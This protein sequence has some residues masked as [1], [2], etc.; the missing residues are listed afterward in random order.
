[1]SGLRPSSGLS[2]CLTACALLALSASA[3]A[4]SAAGIWSVSGQDPQHGP[5]TG[6]VEL[7]AAPGGGYQFVRLI[8]LTQT[9]HAGRRI[10]SAWTGV[11][12]DTGGGVGVDLTLER[13]GWAGS[14]AGIT[15]SAADG[16]PAQV[17]GSFTLQNGA[18]T[19]GWTG[20]GLAL[21]AS[22]TWTR[23]GPVGAAPLWRNER[24]IVGMHRAPG[25][26]VK[27]LM[28]SIFRSYHQTAW[29]QPYVARPDFQ[30]AV[31]SAIHDPTDFDLHRREPDLL[32]VIQRVIDPLSLE[33]AAIKADAY[34]QTLR[35][36]AERADA[37]MPTFIEPT[38]GTL[39]YL[40]NGQAE[41]SGDGDL[42]TG[43]YALSQSLRWQATQD[44]VALA[45]LERSAR[46]AAIAM[47]ID[48]DP[49]AFARTVIPARATPRG[50]KWHAGSG[51]YQ[52]LE[53]LE[54][55]N[56]DMFKGLV[57]TGLAAHEALPA[58]HPLRAELG[59]GLSQ[60]A[61]LSPVANKKTSGNGLL[62]YGLA[63]L[64]TGSSADKDAY[65]RTARNPFFQL[66][67]LLDG[68]FFWQGISDWSG[69]HLGICGVWSRVR[70]S[71]HLNE[72]VEHLA[73]R[74]ALR[75]AEARLRPS[76]PTLH[77]IAAAGRG[78]LSWLS[79]VDASDA[80]WSLR[81]IPFPRS[82][83]RTGHGLRADFSLSPYPSLPWKFDWKTNQ[84]RVQGLVVP[85]RFETSPDIYGWKDNPLASPARG[86]GPGER[87]GAVDY[88]FAYWLAR[89]EGVVGPND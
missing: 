55:G 67:G 3:S 12:H 13:M 85:P 82:E 36:K 65:R 14:G 89:V 6:Q 63:G 74:L 58:G 48:G 35:R 9:R 33:E 40:I 76:R 11:A 53:W 64:L 77:T 84:G 22:E 46:A 66:L 50:G 21:P 72:R 39:T 31:H 38:T 20:G 27:L 4:Q 62:A 68:G 78:R 25:A 49:A 24:T 23:V 15:R 73:S 41:P 47:E 44:P 7:R 17:S 8:E 26:L 75:M 34:G 52:G 51:P 81:E 69:N 45:N 79:R 18:L 61:A 60:L 1:M 80:V 5:Y 71:E 30:A 10:S 42:W 29:V 43:V 2:A 32:R 16:Q 56:N 70:V 88:L 54:G 86:S 37:E 87:D 19:G 57:V 59:H 28:F 83:L